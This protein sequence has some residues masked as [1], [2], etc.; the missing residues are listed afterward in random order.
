MRK[1]R[2]GVNDP[3]FLGEGLKLGGSFRYRWKAHRHFSDSCQLDIF[4]YLHPFAH[5][6]PKC[7]KKHFH[8]WGHFMDKKQGQ[9]HVAPQ[10]ILYF[11][12]LDEIS[13]PTTFE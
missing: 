8:P 5:K 2:F 6:L 9:G 4:R 13:F 1:T 12:K 7:I 10:Q 3:P 11:L